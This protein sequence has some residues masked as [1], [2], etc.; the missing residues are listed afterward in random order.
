MRL[1]QLLQATSS[2]VVQLTAAL[3]VVQRSITSQA[4]QATASPDNTHQRWQVRDECTK[5]ASVSGRL[6]LTEFYSLGETHPP[7]VPRRGHPGY[8]TTVRPYRCA[9]HLGLCGQPVTENS[10]A[11]LK[12]SWSVRP[13]AVEALHPC[14]LTGFCSS[15]LLTGQ[16]SSSFGVCPAGRRRGAG[17]SPSLACKCL[18]GCV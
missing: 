14:L 10:Q 16:G 5:E 11:C 15:D 12:S 7:I 9:H 1:H 3:V 13:R 2:P 8:C 4:L 17:H 18:H 6:D